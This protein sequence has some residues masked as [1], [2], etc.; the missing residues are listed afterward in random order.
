[1]RKPQANPNSK[2][3][4]PVR[5]LFREFRQ[6]VKRVWDAICERIL[7]NTGDFLKQRQPLVWFLALIVGT[8][9]AY[10]A[11]A[12]RW[13]IGFIQW[14]WL[15]TTSENVASAAASIPWW[16]ILTV[17]ALGGLI[18]GCIQQYFISGQRSHAVADVIEAGA[19][20]D[21]R[22]NPQTGFLSA[23]T[24]AISIGTG[25]S[26]G[27]EGPIVHFGATL[28]SLIEE[29]FQ[30]SSSNRR[31]L[32]AS[33]VA[34][35]VS[36]SFNA[37]IAGVL[38]AHEIIL[39]HYGFRALVPVV[40]SSVVGGVIARIHLGDFPAF[41]IPQY[42]ITSYWEFPAFA[43]LGLTCAVVAMAFQFVLIATSRT[44]L[45]ID[46]P[47]WLR[48]TIGGFLVGAIALMFPEILGVGYETTNAALSQKLGLWL[49]LALIVAKTA[50]TAISLATRLSGGIFSP[51]L[52]LGAMTG[53]AFG[54]MASSVFPE[55]GSSQGLYAILG[56]GAV[57]GAV[58]G[59]PLSTILIVF[60]LT[61]GYEMTIAL[62]LTVSISVGITQAVIG[63]SY[64]HWQLARRGFFLQDGPQNSIIRR[65]SV[66]DFMVAAEPDSK[67]PKSDTLRITDTSQTVLLAGDTLEHA[68]RS[69]D[70]SG[71]SRLPVVDGK[72]RTRI[73][74]WA[75]RLNAL[76]L[77]NSALIESHVEAHK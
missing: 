33:G 63:H 8:I 38:F 25:A 61:G 2:D 15:G 71:K 24:A 30:L 50:A 64:F 77:F 28:A 58:L 34:A 57:A 6:F 49:L 72:D 12:F 56:M 76:S 27:R 73:L 32:L 52:Y 69:F 39:G 9:V 51:S 17:P 23:L 13:L 53:G 7:S 26:V 19:V 16:I 21:S 41:M 54:I 60:E 74:A 14:P 62:M 70:K 42:Q 40:I 55:M 18:V 45:M 36:A 75:D 48:A 67:D 1:M 59:A 47:V 10:A 37:P 68:L 66:K 3:E 5:Q 35:A 29:R 44:A 4:N 31:T 22:I 20:H 46:I 43:L 11:I 65:L